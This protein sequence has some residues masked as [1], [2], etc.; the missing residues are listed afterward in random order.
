MPIQ[1]AVVDR[2]ERA[3]KIEAEVEHS[4]QTQRFTPFRDSSIELPVVRIP[5]EYLIYRMGNGRTAVEQMDYIAR[6]DLPIDYFS[7]GEEDSSVQQVQHSILLRMSKDE[8]ASIYTELEHTGR[9]TERLLST[10]T[11]VIVNGNRRLAAIREILQADPNSYRTFSHVDVMV[12]PKGTD[13]SDIETI[14]SELQLIPETKLNY[15]WIERRLKL[16]KHLHKLMM[17]PDIVRQ[18]YRFRGVPDMN[19]E[20]AQLLL[21]EEYLAFIGKPHAYREVHNNEEIFKRL[22]RA[23]DAADGDRLELRKKLAFALIMSSEDLEERL[24]NYSGA[25]GDDLDELLSRYT[26]ESGLEDLLNRGDESTEPSSEVDVL[27]GIEPETDTSENLIE[28]VLD[29]EDKRKDAAK[30]LAGLHRRI[31]REKKEKKSLRAALDSSKDAN[32]ELHSIDL[33]SSDPA[34]F[35]EISSQ[36]KAIIVHCEQLI[37]DIDTLLAE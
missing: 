8:R 17:S 2:I 31:R 24:Y 33:S 27:S 37:T 19:R 7:T 32:S 15:G 12:L 14:E 23:I 36:L 21:A 1:I 28:D 29:D 30:D 5:T 16:R 22:Q 10:C 25:F 9:Q 35:E 13:E 20:L 11:G 4:E 34:T 18:M 3:R 6:M 26:E